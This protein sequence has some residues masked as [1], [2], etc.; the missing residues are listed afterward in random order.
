MDPIRSAGQF[1]FHVGTKGS[2]WRE[3]VKKGRGKEKPVKDKKHSENADTS[4]SVTFDL[5]CDLYLTSR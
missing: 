3:D 4:M 2:K 5:E 1:E